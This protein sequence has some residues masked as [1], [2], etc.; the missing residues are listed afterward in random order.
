MS[1]TDANVKIKMT[2][3]DN[4]S[5]VVDRV[6][7]ST[8]NMANQ[9]NMNDR[10]MSRHRRT[11]QQVGFQVGDFATQIA[12]GQ[13][14]MLAFTQQGGQLLQF[15]GPFGA[16][17]AGLLA[18]FGSMAIAVTRSGKSLSDL[19][20]MMGILQDEFAALGAAITK[21]KEI[22][23]DFANLVVN[24]LDRITVIAG[25]IVAFFAVKWV[26]AFVA[27]RV[28]TFS[29]I[30]AL[31]LLKT[32]MLR[33]LP[34]AILIGLGELV[35]RFIQLKK[36]VGSFGGVLGLIGELFSEF[37]DR[38]ETGLVSLAAGFKSFVY[39]MEMG[40]RNALAGMLEGF[41]DFLDGVTSM[42][43]TDGVVLGPFRAF[44]FLIEK[45]TSSLN[46]QANALRESAASYGDLSEALADI[47]LKTAQ[48][49]SA[50]FKTLEKIRE[51]VA[52]DAQ[53]DVRNFFKG[54]EEG[55]D[56]ASGKTD[57]L[58]KSMSKIQS[59]V[60]SGLESVF[61]AA[62][63]G[64]D[65]A[66]EALRKMGL[67][68]LKVV[69]KMQLYQFLAKAMPNIFGHGGFAP[70]VNATGQ[71]TKFAQGGVVNGPTPF[72]MANGMG[73]MGEAG[74]EAI[75][76]LSRGPDGKLGVKGGG[77][78]VTIQI[79]N[80]S[81]SNIRRETTTDSSGQRI[82]RLI[83]DA[84]GRGM[85]NGQLDTPMIGRFGDKPVKKVR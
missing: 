37:I 60:K 24:N 26:A 57:K 33:F 2:G 79:V 83:I 29:L 48:S 52:D 6:S 14:A 62:F 84:V 17:A 85:T 36:A 64:A 30:G 21:S 65:K 7:R 77:A 51:L 80:N 53:I 18:V 67:E 16:A 81:Q 72:P 31:S 22:L 35:F 58:S 34:T 76:P 11:I 46:T 39:G 69:A 3:V 8:R 68:L 28:A 4:A 13:S 61:Q 78:N 45:S 82:E 15:F 47:S 44:N 70:L 20:P 50:P 27:A 63:Q 71:V 42:L 9:I 43:P 41:R 74:P 1:S 23:I 38:I 19:A 32:A 54:V 66:V 56:G 49:M 5:R 25:T 10:F 73:V 12:G 55:A 40:W 59:I 75:M